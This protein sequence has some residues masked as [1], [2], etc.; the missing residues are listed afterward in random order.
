VIY[1]YTAYAFAGGYGLCYDD[2]D[3]DDYKQNAAKTTQERNESHC[4]YI[5]L[6]CTNI[7][8]YY[9]ILLLFITNG[10]SA[11]T[12]ASKK[13]KYYTIQYMND[14]NSRVAFKDFE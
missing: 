4:I 7:L 1:T 10:F 11:V 14:N 13:T 2:G 5:I 6:H 12:C 3:D 9:Y 8:Q